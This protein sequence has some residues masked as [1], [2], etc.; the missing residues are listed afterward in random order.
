MNAIVSFWVTYPRL[1][2]I[3]ACKQLEQ[4][5]TGLLAAW[6][7]V[8]C[9]LAELHAWHAHHAARAGHSDTGHPEYAVV[10]QTAW[11]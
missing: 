7:L 10:N 3:N 2:A 4:D 8:A 1:C 11:V 9:L 6:P 5:I